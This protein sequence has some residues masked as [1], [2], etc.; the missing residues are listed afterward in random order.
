MEVGRDT[1]G[2]ADRGTKL[3][4]LYPSMLAMAPTLA[5]M[6]ENAT[7]FRFSEM[8]PGLVAVSLTPVV[9]WPI[10]WSLYRE[11]SRAI[12]TTAVFSLVFVTFGSVHRALPLPAAVI[13]VLAVVLCAAV[14]L[15]L[16]RY[17]RVPS[18]LEKGL[19]AFSA[20]MVAVPTL[21]LALATLSPP[22]RVLPPAPQVPAQ[23]TRDSWPDVYY[24]VLDGFGAAATLERVYDL[25]GAPF[26]RSLEDLGFFIGE[27]SAANYSQTQLSVA[28]TLNLSY[29]D[30][31]IADMDP[32]SSDHR[33]LWRL[34]QRNALVT[35][36]GGAGYRFFAFESGYGPTSIRSAEHYL[37]P[38]LHLGIFSTA[39]AQM[40]L[41]PLVL[42]DIPLLD[43]VEAHRTR[44]LYTLDE[45]P[46][47][48]E[49]RGPKFVYAHVLSP[50]PPFVFD[51]S[52]APSRE[53]VPYSVLD[54]S[55]FLGSPEEYRRGYVEQVRFVSD[56]VVDL[57][58]EILRRS[59][60]PPVIVIQGDH[61]PGL[62]LDQESRENT[63]LAERLLILNALY[64]PDSGAE[65]LG[66]DLSPVNTFRHVLNHYLGAEYTLLPHRSYYSTFSRPYDFQDVTRLVQAATP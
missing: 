26:L 20:F 32:E 6:A 31:L 42:P 36:L 13:V 38:P 19:V 17:Q 9:F 59:E 53:D 41:L 15:G 52:G 22:A 33:P 29:V 62:N 47:V 27:G 50:H 54:G 14:A 21:S 1:P 30:E 34:I 7:H 4:L 60:R 45:L 43:F 49:E 51:A 55:H 63:D 8:L 44:I 10:A 18:R 46:R 11:R 57:V 16:R 35:T 37:R 61:G 48:A 66:P 2:S 40:T 23:G 24:I 56:R 5:L 39:V 64:L 58:A 25:D 28:A 12:L 65:G 3:A